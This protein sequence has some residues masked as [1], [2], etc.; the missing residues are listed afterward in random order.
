MIPKRS[1]A[2]S[3]IEPAL[4]RARAMLEKPDLPYRAWIALELRLTYMSIHLRMT[5]SKVPPRVAHRGY[6]AEGRA[7]HDPEAMHQFLVVKKLQL[8][9]ARAMAEY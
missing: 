1:A 8:E 6:S 3:Q 9:V 2:Y 7:W 4:R 5:G